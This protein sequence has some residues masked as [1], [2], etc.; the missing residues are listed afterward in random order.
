M[1]IALKDSK[2]LYSCNIIT[3]VKCE[4]WKIV[5]TS[6]TEIPVYKNE[7]FNTMHPV[8]K[9]RLKGNLANKALVYTRWNNELIYKMK[10]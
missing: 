7:Q 10:E 6:N 1:V 4:L 5:W 8:K 9:V 2:E 3:F